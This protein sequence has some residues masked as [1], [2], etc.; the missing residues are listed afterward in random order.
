MQIGAMFTKQEI[1]LL[2]TNEIS[3]AKCDELLI[4]FFKKIRGLYTKYKKVIN[5]NDLDNTSLSEKYKNIRTAGLFEHIL[6]ASG[7][8][9]NRPVYVIPVYMLY[10]ACTSFI[11]I[12]MCI[13]LLNILMPIHFSSLIATFT[14]YNAHVIQ[15]LFSG[16]ITMGS[17]YFIKRLSMSI[18]W[19]KVSMISYVCFSSALFSIL[20]VLVLTIV[21]ASSVFLAVFILL[22]SILMVASMIFIIAKR[23][24]YT[25]LQPLLGLLL[26]ACVIF[27]LSVGLSFNL[28]NFSILL[29]QVSSLH[30]PV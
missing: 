11:F 19:A 10:F 23:S 1:N 3:I 5:L 30:I 8:L 24:V 21:K 6:S 16:L 28:F 15:I 29:R 17:I 18:R 12:S 2:D 22:M 13:V 4:R 7:Y 20:F 9:N 14:V 25:H 27:G 26:I